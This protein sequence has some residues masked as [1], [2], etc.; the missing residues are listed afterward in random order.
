VTV[1]SVVV[2]GMRVRPEAKGLNL[3]DYE[4]CVSVCALD[5]PDSACADISFTNS[6]AAGCVTA[7]FVVPGHDCGDA[8][9]QTKFRGNVA[10]S[11]K[12]A[13]ANIFPDVAGNDHTSCYEGSHFAAYKV[14]FS[15]VSTNFVGMEQR[16]SNLVMV[17]N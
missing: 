12:G 2:T 15:G 1:D 6:I 9:T 3:R 8:D 16:M 10:H 7:G 13:G 17:D 5:G 4:S 14:S 11:I